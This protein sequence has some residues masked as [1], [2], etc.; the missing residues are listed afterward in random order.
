MKIIGLLLSVLALL[1]QAGSVWDGVYAESQVGRGRTLYTEQCASCHGSMLEGAGQTPPLAGADFLKGWEGQPLK[2]LFEKVQITMPADGPG[3]LAKEQS[4][5][6]VAFMLQANGFPPGASALTPTHE[7][8]RR[9]YRT[10]CPSPSPL[11]GHSSP[12]RHTMAQ[13]ARRRSWRPCVRS[14]VP[15]RAV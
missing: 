10:P 5:D 2:D 11:A 13:Q 12:T 6:L 8:R 15:I 3:R 4:A 9:C 7:A 14:T 1:T